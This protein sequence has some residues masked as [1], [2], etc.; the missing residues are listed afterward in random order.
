MIDS[1]LYHHHNLP[2]HHQSHN[3]QEQSSS[4]YPSMSLFGSESSLESS[5]PL[6]SS[7]G[8]EMASQQRVIANVRER[9]RT[10]SLN[11]AF[12]L[13]RQLIPSLPSDKLSKI[14]TLKLATRYIQFLDEVRPQ[15]YCVFLALSLQL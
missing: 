11:S 10:E 15:P 8:F 2:N 1:L 9:K 6:S 14:Q 13:L 7:V 5:P 12:T 4:M 3:Q